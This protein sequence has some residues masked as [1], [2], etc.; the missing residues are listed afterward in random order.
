MP[1]VYILRCRDGSLYTGSAKDVARRLAQHQIGRAS[2]YT[3]SRL[4]VA[5]VWTRRVGSWSRALREERRIKVL[6]R[7]RKEALL[8]AGRAPARTAGSCR[9]RPGGHPGSAIGEHLNTG[10]E[11]GRRDADPPAGMRPPPRDHGASRRCK[12]SSIRSIRFSSRSIRGNTSAG[13]RPP[14]KIRSAGTRRPKSSSS[15]PFIPNTAR[16]AALGPVT[17][18]W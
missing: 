16:L 10:R 14:S 15:A 1:C 11:V 17:A 2:R 12:A 5:L 8:R 13:Y 3:R 7:A 18:L 4:P 6:T 9:P